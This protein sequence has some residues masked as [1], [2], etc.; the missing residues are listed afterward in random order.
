M[1]QGY[2]IS[3]TI[4]N[5]V[6]FVTLIKRKPIIVAARS[7]AWNVFA[8]SNAG[9]VGLNPTQGMEVWDYSVFV[10][11]YVGNGVGQ[12]NPL[13]EESY[14]LYKIKKLK[15]N[16]ALMPYATSRSNRNR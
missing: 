5:W 8:R 7:K 11:S 6:L 2:V 13:S 4:M 15:W 12:A 1:A 9:I 14:R 3:A 16:E 10:L